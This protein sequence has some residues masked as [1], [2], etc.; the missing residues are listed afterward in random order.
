MGEERNEAVGRCEG[1]REGAVLA[2]GCTEAVKTKL[3]EA[4]RVGL[5]VALAL[6][7]RSK[8]EALLLAP[9]WE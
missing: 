5:R 8:Q 7:G 2:D 6:P 9:G 3:A 1:E 4:V